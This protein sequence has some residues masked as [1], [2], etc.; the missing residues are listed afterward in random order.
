MNFADWCWKY[1]DLRYTNKSYVTGHTSKLFFLQKSIF[2]TRS[3]G[4]TS[5]YRY[6]TTERRS[7]GQLFV[8]LLFK[9][10][11]WHTL[12]SR[13][14]VWCDIILRLESGSNATINE[15]MQHFW[16]NLGPAVDYETQRRRWLVRHRHTVIGGYVHPKETKNRLRLYI[17]TEG[18]AFGRE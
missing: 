8:S 12:N 4:V 18:T 13:S 5:S 3:L 9:V 10:L 16:I 6:V 15:L 1:A 14:L 11:D 7:Q 17:S 2:F